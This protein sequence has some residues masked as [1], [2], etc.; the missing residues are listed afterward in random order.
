MCAVTGIDLPI[1]ATANQKTEHQ[2]PLKSKRNSLGYVTVAS[3]RR[4]SN[5]KSVILRRLQHARRAE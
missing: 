4:R 2:V 3:R 1:Y 5:I